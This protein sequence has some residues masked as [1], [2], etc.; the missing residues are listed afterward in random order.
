MLEDRAKDRRAVNQRIAEI[1]QVDGIGSYEC[2]VDY[3]PDGALVRALSILEKVNRDDGMEYEVVD[4]TRD[5]D[6]LFRVANQI[7]LFLEIKP[8]CTS[9][10]GPCIAYEASCYRQH[11][12]DDA[13]RLEQVGE[14]MSSLSDPSWIA[15][16]ALYDA[17]YELGLPYGS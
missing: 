16:M 1:D 4:Y 15:A 2:N 13:L 12:E 9:F 6:S 17:I 3:L 10:S 11:M 7:E 5:T 8:V 14:T